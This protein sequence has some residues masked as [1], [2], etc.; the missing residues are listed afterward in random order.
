MAVGALCLQVRAPCLNCPHLLQVPMLSVTGCLRMNVATHLSSS[1]LPRS[2]GADR[3]C[4][5]SRG[6]FALRGGCERVSSDISESSS[7][8][9]A[10]KL[11]FAVPDR[12]TPNTLLPG[13]VAHACRECY[14][15]THVQKTQ[16]YCT[17]SKLSSVYIV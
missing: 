11:L 5:C 4:S 10:P 15:Q 12:R 7:W 1:G 13:R 14:V 3:S 8:P 2:S 6:Q 16:H 17:A 9:L